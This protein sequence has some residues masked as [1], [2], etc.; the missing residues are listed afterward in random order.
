MQSLDI[1]KV[2]KI[3][4]N[5]KAIIFDMDGT[6]AL[7]TDLELNCFVKLFG[8]NKKFYK[9]YFGP[10]SDKIISELRP[11]FSFKQV[12]IFNHLWELLYTRKLKKNLWISKKTINILKEL[13]KKYILGI[14]TSSVRKTAIITL[15]DC[16]SVFDFLFCAEQQTKH[17]PNPDSLNKIMSQ[18][19]LKPKNVVYIG[20]NINDIL[21]GKNAKTKTIGK[22][23]ILYNKKQLQKCNPDLIIT[24]L[25]ELECLL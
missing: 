17:K 18:Y 7:T 16:Y 11:N 20:D 25:S 10:P 12:R 19:K 22:I 3:K 5:L 2:N 24:D 14:I 23:D 15:R 9:K 21:F 6:I 13:K 1:K 4:K 8:K